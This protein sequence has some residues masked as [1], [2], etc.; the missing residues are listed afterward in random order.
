MH[1]KTFI[2]KEF[3]NCRASVAVL[4]NEQVYFNLSTELVDTKQLDISGEG[5][6]DFI[7][8]ELP[9]SQSNYIIHTYIDA[10]KEVQDWLI[11]A[12]ELSVFDGDYYGTGRNY[13]PGWY[14]IGLLI[15]YKWRQG[16]NRSGSSVTVEDE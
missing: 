5:Y 12:T 8:P 3:R 1:Y 10:G 9:L 15:K 11:D 4:R 16:N 14:G 13:P 6:I 7:I 2:N